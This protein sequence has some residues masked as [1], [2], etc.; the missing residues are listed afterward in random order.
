MK[1]RVSI[2]VLILSM[3]VTSGFS[4][5]KTR[6]EKKEERKMEKQK[7]IEAMIN[8]KEFVF[9][10]QTVLPSRMKPVNIS[11]NGNY[12]KFQPDYI[13]SYMPFFGRAYSGV[14]YGAD[15]GLSFNGT[16]EKFTLDKKG[17]TFQIN[18][19]VRGGSNTFRLFLSVGFEGNTSLSISSNNRET[20]S[21][22]GEISALER[23]GNK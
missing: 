23:M 9:V 18:V 2:L 1:A 14:G 6:R 21:Y 20:S 8:A 11:T 17:K 4:Q 10:P 16:P 15:A 19:V 13:D 22:Q 12:I 5:D 7:E 3:I